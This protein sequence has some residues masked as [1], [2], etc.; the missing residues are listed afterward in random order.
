VT[1]VNRYVETNGL[2]YL[3][4]IHKSDF[5]QDPRQ[6]YIT[7]GE[8]QAL[9]P[10]EEWEILRHDVQEFTDAP[11]PRSS[12]VHKLLWGTFYAKKLK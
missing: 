4:Y 8:L 1:A 12:K 11:N 6:K 10:S 5:D 3:E 9:Y 7:A 2:L